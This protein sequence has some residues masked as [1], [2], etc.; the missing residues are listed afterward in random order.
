M[1]KILRALWRRRLFTFLNIFG[2][3]VSI[4]ASWIIFRIVSYEFSYD[5][6]LPNKEN[7]YKVITALNSVDRTN[8][9]M[10]GVAAPL[11]QGVRAEI[12]GVAN[13]VPVFKKRVNSIEIRG[14]DKIAIKEDPDNIIA[15]DASY[16]NMLPYQW[17]AGSRASALNGPNKVVLTESR[18]REY[19]PNQTP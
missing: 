5:H 9:K 15:T 1:L 16:F 3:A 12:P 2:L 18:A 11:Y 4:S 10:G 19:F 8:A 14:T 7:T 6:A 17:I 13:V